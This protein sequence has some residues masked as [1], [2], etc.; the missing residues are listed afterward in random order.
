VL[1]EAN[2][3]GNK[4]KLSRKEYKKLDWL[5]FGDGFVLYISV[6]LILLTITNNVLLKKFL[7]PSVPSRET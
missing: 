5:V 4:E 6:G 2:I 3:T 7:G 1:Y